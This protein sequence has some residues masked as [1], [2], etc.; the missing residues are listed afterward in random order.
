MLYHTEYSESSE[1]F[2][3]ARLQAL[4][5]CNSR[6]A[7]ALIGSVCIIVDRYYDERLMDSD[8]SSSGIFIR[9]CLLMPALPTHRS[10]NSLTKDEI[11]RAMNHS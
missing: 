8:L 2:D 3:A 4:R 5:H 9:L 10:S 7:P 11:P 6:P 1:G